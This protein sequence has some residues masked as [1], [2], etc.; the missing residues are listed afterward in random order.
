MD[1]LVCYDI[2]ETDGKGAVRLRKIADVCSQYG[3]RVQYSVFECRISSERYAR[4]LSE[5]ED[6]IEADLDN[7]VVYRFAGNINNAKTTLGIRRDHE[8]GEPWVL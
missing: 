3:E 5:I 2:A 7:V 4:L 8:I 1:I 6:V